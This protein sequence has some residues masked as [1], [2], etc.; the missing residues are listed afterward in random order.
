MIRTLSVPGTLNYQRLSH[1]GF[2]PGRGAFMLQYVPLQPEMQAVRSLKDW[3]FE[4][5]DFDVV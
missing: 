3:H 1:C 5:G 2:L 4:G